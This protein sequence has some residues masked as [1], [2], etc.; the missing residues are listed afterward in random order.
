MGTLYDVAEGRC[1]QAVEAPDVPHPFGGL[2]ERA[3]LVRKALTDPSSDEIDGLVDRLLDDSSDFRDFVVAALKDE[4]GCDLGERFKQWASLK[5]LHY[6][7]DVA[8]DELG[9]DE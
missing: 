3:R 8:R 5:A 4:P 2:D 6:S 7:Y 1:E 9:V